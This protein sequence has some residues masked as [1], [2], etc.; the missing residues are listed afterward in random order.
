MRATGVNFLIID[1]VH[2]LAKVID[3]SG[4]ISPSQRRRVAV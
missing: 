4:F 1:E 3:E 2:N